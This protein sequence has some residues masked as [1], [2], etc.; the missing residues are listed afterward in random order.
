[1]R[2]IL[3]IKNDWQRHIRHSL[4]CPSKTPSI[5]RGSNKESDPRQ[6]L[7]KPRAS[8]VKNPSSSISPPNERSLP[9]EIG[10]KLVFKCCDGLLL[11]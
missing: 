9:I 8:N 5:V 2:E 10:I 1:M 7:Q 6:T 4:P 3:N 11:T